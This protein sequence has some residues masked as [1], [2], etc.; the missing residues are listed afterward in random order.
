[1]KRFFGVCLTLIFILIASG[2]GSR[3]TSNKYVDFR[4]TV[5]MPTTTKRPNDE[6]ALKVAIASVLLPQDTVTSY[7]NYSRLSW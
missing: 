3:A 5:P 6:H 7:L 4:K 1:M 2:C